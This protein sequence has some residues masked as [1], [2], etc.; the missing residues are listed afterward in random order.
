MQHPV[1][2]RFP[3]GCFYAPTGRGASTR[4]RRLADSQTRRLADGGGAMHAHRPG[5]KK[6]RGEAVAYGSIRLRQA[7]AERKPL[8]LNEL[9]APSTTH[10]TRSTPPWPPNEKASNQSIPP[11]EF[12]TP[13]TPSVAKPALNA[14]YG[15]HPPLA[16]TL[17]PADEVS[18]QRLPAVAGEAASRR[19]ADATMGH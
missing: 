12:F 7:V 14:T 5:A 17:S 11:L 18:A 10:G 8:W 3:A 16:P 4:W 2:E 9:R 15:L 13:S 19:G 6:T 1:G